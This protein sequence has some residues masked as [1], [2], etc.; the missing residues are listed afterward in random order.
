MQRS[1]DGSSES[2][3]KKDRAKLLRALKARGKGAFPVLGPGFGNLQGWTI[4]SGVAKS[5]A[6]SIND[7][8][9]PLTLTILIKPSAYQYATTPGHRV[10]CSED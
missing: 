5:Q 1:H 9:Y 10:L 2:L 8:R 7:V 3:E 6:T 4:H